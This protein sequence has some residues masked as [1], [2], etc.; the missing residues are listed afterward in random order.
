MD[1]DANVDRD[2]VAH[3]DGWAITDAYCHARRDL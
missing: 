1:S 3:S 2:A